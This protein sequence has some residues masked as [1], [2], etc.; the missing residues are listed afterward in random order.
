M[1][2][3]ETSP[4]SP[5]LTL[6]QFFKLWTRMDQFNSLAVEEQQTDVV[7]DVAA[8]VVLVQFHLSHCKRLLVWI[9]TVELMTADHNTQLG[10]RHPVT[11][12]A[13]SDDDIRG[14][15]G[16]TTH[17]AATHPPG[18]HDLVRELAPRSISAANNSATSAVQGSVLKFRRAIGKSQAYLKNKC[19][20]VGAK[21]ATPH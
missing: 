1:G 21:E 2:I 17:E 16:S 5:T 9:L 20:H 4:T 18:Q 7:V 6:I 15:K 10:R 3:L 8:V 11:T 13:G 14:N 12:V 19:T